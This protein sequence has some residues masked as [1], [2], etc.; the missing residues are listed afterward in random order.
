MST[1]LNA[2]QQAEERLTPE[3]LAVWTKVCGQI[4]PDDWGLLSGLMLM[5]EHGWEYEKIAPFIPGKRR[6]VDYKTTASGDS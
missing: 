5:V 1:P 4:G 6:V 2:I 3:Q